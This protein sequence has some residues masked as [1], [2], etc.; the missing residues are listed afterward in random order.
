M[1]NHPLA[2]KVILRAEGFVHSPEDPPAILTS[3]GKRQVLH[4]EYEAKFSCS[5]IR[6]KL[7]GVTTRMASTS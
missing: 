4:H 2:W 3:P 6:M 1:L 7:R 5:N